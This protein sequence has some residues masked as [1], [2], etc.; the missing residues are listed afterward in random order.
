[1][2]RSKQLAKNR[3]RVKSLHKQ[4]PERIWWVQGNERQ[5]GNALPAIW[6]CE[7]FSEAEIV[8]IHMKN[9]L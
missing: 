9:H 8:T 6:E 2:S 5:T 3:N 4:I 7:M 1:V